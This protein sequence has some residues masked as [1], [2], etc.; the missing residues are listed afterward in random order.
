LRID[1]AF[2]AMRRSGNTDA[3]SYRLAQDILGGAAPWLLD[4]IV[5]R[6]LEP[7]E[8]ALA[9]DQEEKPGSLRDEVHALE[10]VKH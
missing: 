8:G 7:V 4:G 6:K 5:A 9:L 1:E 2:R 3:K 10:H